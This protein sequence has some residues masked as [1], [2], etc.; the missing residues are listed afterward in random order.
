LYNGECLVVE[1]QST[2]DFS[3]SDFVEFDFYVEDANAIKSA[4]ERSNL[5]FNVIKGY[6]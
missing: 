1:K 6:E 3:Q 2:T 4:M 5:W